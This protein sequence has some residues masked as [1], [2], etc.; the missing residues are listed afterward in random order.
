MAGKAFDHTFE[1]NGTVT[2]RMNGGKPSS[3]HHY[4]VAACSDSVEL[5][6]YLGTS[7]YTL[8]VA[9]NFDDRSLVAVASNEKELVVQHGRFEML[10]EQPEAHA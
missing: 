4:E 1:R 5:V 2:W 3:E 8:T 10:P 6:S 7:G 9:L